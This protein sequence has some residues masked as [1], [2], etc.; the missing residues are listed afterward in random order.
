[1]ARAKHTD[2][3]E[4]R[5]RHRAE[6]AALAAAS[7]DDAPEGDAPAGGTVSKA[8]ATK[9]A[10][11]P[12]AQRPSIMSAFRGAYR[13]V[14]LRSDLRAFPA[15]VTHWAVLA[16]MAIAI[17]STIAFIVSTNDFGASLDVSV[18]Q[19]LEGREIGMVTN[20]T[21]LVI[22]LFV[23]PP[24][25]AG[26]FLIGFTAQRASWLGGLVF[27]IV[28]AICYSVIVAMPAGRLLIG[29]NPPE[30]FAVQAMVMGPIGALLFASMAAW[31]KRFLNLANPN[32][33]ARRA[34]TKTQPKQ[35]AKPATAKSGTRSR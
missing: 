23:A 20:A 25:A 35:K 10:T 28:A 3:T 31:Y 27:G 21:Y 13:P 5:R 29:G 26:A 22:S 12:P 30:A 16:S 7:P 32:R 18:A 15:V 1:L 9:G 2:R 33:G 8:P 4:A 19:P 34:N 14:D 11:A 17:V 6:Q 24:P